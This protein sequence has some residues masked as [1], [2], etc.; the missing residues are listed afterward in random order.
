MLLFTLFILCVCVCII[1]IVICMYICIHVFY[2]CQV[3]FVQSNA[4]II[5]C[6]PYAF[7]LYLF[8]DYVKVV[9]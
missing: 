9:C 3:F 8:A 4:R 2:N 5:I 6:S 1:N 7:T